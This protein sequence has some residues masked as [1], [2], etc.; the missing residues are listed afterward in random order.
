M[1]VTG[2]SNHPST[3]ALWAGSADTPIH[4]VTLTPNHPHTQPPLHLPDL[5]TLAD[6]A[7]TLPWQPFRPGVEIHRLYGDGTGPSAALLRYQPG[8]QVPHHTHTG[9][10]HIFVLAGSQRDRHQTYAAGSLVINSP[11]T[12]HAV[13]SDEGCLVLI[14]W[15]KPVV[16]HNP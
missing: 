16:I 8:A 10:E 13:A 1:S 5:W 6:R 4:P 12:D 14:I 7:D 15:E 2:L 11:G 9:Y 3:Q